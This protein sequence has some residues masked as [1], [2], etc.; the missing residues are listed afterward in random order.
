MIQCSKMPHFSRKPGDRTSLI[1]NR[2]I[3]RTRI[4]VA[5]TTCVVSSVSSVSP[6]REAGV[7]TPCRRE[8]PPPSQHGG[9]RVAAPIGHHVICRSLSCL[10]REARGNRGVVS[11]ACSKSFTLEGICFSSSGAIFLAR[12]TEAV[13]GSFPCGL[14]MRPRAPITLPAA[15]CRGKVTSRLPSRIESI[16]ASCGTPLS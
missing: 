1:P 4:R 9:L 6:P 14:K 16:P 8:R 15:V 3:P 5:G 12:S 11:L 10:L 7:Q 13:S 2:L